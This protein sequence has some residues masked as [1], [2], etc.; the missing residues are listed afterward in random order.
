MQECRVCGLLFLGGGACPSC[1]SQVAIDISIDDVVMDDD[2]IPGLDDV[3]DA[4]GSTDDEA[5]SAEVLPFGMGAKAE[6]LDSSLPFG[7]GSFTEGAEDMA[8]PSSDLDSDDDNEDEVTSEP[9]GYPIHIEE[10][11][12]GIEMTEEPDVIYENE[13]PSVDYSSPSFEELASISSPQIPEPENLPLPELEQTPEVF[14]L[15][16]DEPLEEITT[17]ATPIATISVEATPDVISDEVPDMWRIDAAAV[18]LDEIYSQEEQVIEVSFDD[19]LG[20]GDVEVTF[21]EFHHAAVEDSMASDD[22]APELHPARALATDA[23][24]QPEVAQMVNSAFSH[25]GNSAWIEAAQV[26]SSASSMRQNDPSILNNLGLALLQSALEMDSAG[27]PMSS[28]QYEAA[29]MALRQGAKIEP[30]N[31]TLLLNLGHALL[32]SGR[33]EKAL[34]VINV[35]RSRDSSNIEIENALGA[36]LIQLGREEEAMPILTPFAN[37]RIVSANIALI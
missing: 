8:I 35:V 23:Q 3:V 11:E 26:L 33:A 30:D 2:S 36:C 13:M 28:S 20:S 14:R 9:E 7:V 19:D 5:D 29:I 21:D 22:D 17:G 25:M 12:E 10:T 16:A 15:T 4:I 24:G 1:G 18:D 27:D 6:V 37:D 32:V 31:N 34:G